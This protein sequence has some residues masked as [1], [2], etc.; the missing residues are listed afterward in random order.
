MPT[1]F[2]ATRPSG[3]SKRTEFKK[4]LGEEMDRLQ[5]VMAA[6]GIASRRA[7]EQMILEG[8]VSVNGEKITQLGFQ[9][10]DEDTVTVDGES[11]KKEAK[12]YYVINKPAG[13]LSTNA[14]DKNR[15][16]VTDLIP[17][18]ERIFPV[19]R[20]DYD[21]TGTLLLTNDGDFM[22]ALIHPKFQVEKEYHVKVEGLL[23]KEE[24]TL[25]EKGI[26]IG[27]GITTAPA[28]IFDVRYDETKTNTYLKIVI[29]EGK[30]HEIKRMFERVS[31][32]VIKLTRARFGGI[33]CDGLKQGEYRRLKPH[34]I[35]QL[36]NL[37]RFGRSSE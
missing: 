34:E 7:S 33:T 9:V 36:W 15:R 11:I 4:G 5:K 6:A 29:H 28:R 20:L 31:H 25:V 19:G 37:S 2:K 3:R 35:K 21:T 8:R 18:K 12:V 26:D 32:P 23:R 30:Y 13:C 17:C 14:D 22:N 1:F 10:S 27:D 24:S 16:T